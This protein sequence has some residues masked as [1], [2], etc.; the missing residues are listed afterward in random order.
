[1][2]CEDERGFVADHQ[3]HLGNPPDA[4]QLVPAVK[5]VAQVTDPLPGRWSAT[6][7]SV[8]PQSTVSWPSLA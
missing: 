6:A 4:P 7:G 2:V 1:L 3:V 5:Q 8:P